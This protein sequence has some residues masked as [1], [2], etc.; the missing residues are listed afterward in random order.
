[1]TWPVLFGKS[2]CGPIASSLTVQRPD[3]SILI[4]SALD[5]KIATNLAGFYALESGTDYLVSTGN[6]L[7]FEVLRS[8]AD[9]TIST[10]D[11]DLFCRF[12]NATWKASQ[13][14]RGISRIERLT[15]APF[16]FLNE[17]DIDKD[18]VQVRAAARAV[19]SKL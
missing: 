19:L 2:G 11:K 16:Y 1:M 17:A 9:G 10:A 15:F 14:F 13:P 3:S 4:K 5:E 8:I 12:A 18:W 6:R 7:P